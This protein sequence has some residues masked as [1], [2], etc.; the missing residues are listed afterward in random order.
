MQSL[1]IWDIWLYMVWYGSF[2]CGSNVFLYFYNFHISC[3]RISSEVC[4]LL[5]FQTCSTEFKE[6]AICK[7]QL[8]LKENVETQL[9]MEI[10]PSEQHVFD[11]YGQCCSFANL[12]EWCTWRNFWP[13]NGKISWIF[14][15]FW[16]YVCFCCLVWTSET[17]QLASSCWHLPK[18]CHPVGNLPK[19]QFHQDTRS[20][21]L[22]SAW[23]GSFSPLVK[24]RMLTW[25]FQI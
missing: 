21:G 25:N 4:F 11:N 8:P 7:V 22:E 10:V 23:M 12:G 20:F 13:S 16:D 3:A 2:I 18:C 6:H 15:S 5:C 9:E 17:N 19:H 14:R 1:H 24:V